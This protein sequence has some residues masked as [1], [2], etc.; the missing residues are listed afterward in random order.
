VPSEALSPALAGEG[1]AAAVEAAEMAPATPAAALVEAPPA[2]EPAAPVAALAPAPASAAAAA[3]APA[4]ARPRPPPAGAAAAVQTIVLPEWTG[5]KDAHAPPPRADKRA[6]KLKPL[7]LVASPDPD[8]KRPQPVD[9]SWT[10]PLLLACTV[11]AS[12]LGGLALIAAS[13]GGCMVLHQQRRRKIEQSTLPRT[14]SNTSVYIPCSDD[15]DEYPM[16][17]LAGGV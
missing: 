11:A 15:E 9:L 4:A 10:A 8:S 1:A 2:P 13:C 12:V 3:G 14:Y 6:P 17:G 5:P 7:Q 16:K